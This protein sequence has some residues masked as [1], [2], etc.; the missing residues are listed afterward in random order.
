MKKYLFSLLTVVITCSHN[1]YAVQ[2]WSSPLKDPAVHQTTT[3]TNYFVSKYASSYVSGGY[4]YSFVP[5]NDTTVQQ[6][7]NGQPVTLPVDDH[8]AQTCSSGIAYSINPD[9]DL[10]LRLSWLSGYSVNFTVYI[11]GDHNCE[12]AKAEVNI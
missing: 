2:E 7:Q 10:I 8:L 11:D 1:S 5:N 4:I 9:V 6:V 12:I 3:F